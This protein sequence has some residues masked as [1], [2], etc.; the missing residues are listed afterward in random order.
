[1]GI[2]IKDIA[3]KV[4]VSTTTVSKVL[5]KK[6]PNISKATKEKIFNVAKEYN[7]IPNIIAKSLKN[8]K[9]FTLAIIIPDICNP[10]FAKIAKAVQR[11]ANENNYSVLICNTDD[12]L[13]EEKNA[14]Q[15]LKSRMV[16][17]IIIS[18]V[19]VDYIKQI[20]DSYVIPIVLIDRLSNNESNNLYSVGINQELEFYKI[21]SYLF[22]KGRRDFA[23]I[24][25]SSISSDLRK[26]GV[27]QFLKENNKELKQIYV[28]SY[29]IQTGYDGCKE[30]LQTKDKIDS[31][32]CANDLIA[33]GVIKYLKE[34]GIK[35]P[36]SISVT[37]F[38]DIDMATHIEPKLTTTNQPVSFIGEQAIK[39]LIDKIENKN[40][41]QK[42]II[43]CKLIIRES[44]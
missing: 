20:M 35:I 42:V 13:E 39:L 3:N 10:Y 16:D 22:N 43:K 26:N 7:Y 18:S 4:G 41:F 34:V 11:V 29:D 17:G 8:K 1:M 27:I 44:A 37:G 21:T 24:G 36:E 31:I 28:G 38:D 12:K 33:I 2:S 25:S 30:I 15:V 5:N 23:Y 32:I 6:A 40:N 19:D 9:T 14:L